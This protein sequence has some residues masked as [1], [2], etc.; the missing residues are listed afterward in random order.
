[1]NTKAEIQ[2]LALQNMRLAYKIAWKYRGRGIEQEE[3]QSAALYGLVKAA[4][5]YDSSRKVTFPAFAC[6][7]MQRNDA[8][9]SRGAD[10][11]VAA[12]CE[13]AYPVG[14]GENKEEIY[15]DHVSCRDSAGYDSEKQTGGRD[16][17]QIWNQCEGNP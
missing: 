10:R 4:S 9:G 15:G 14:N 2:K 5:G 16:Y 3:L 12:P 13:Q 1:M 17:A 8:E 11:S 7:V 6:A